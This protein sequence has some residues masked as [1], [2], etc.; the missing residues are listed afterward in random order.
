MPTLEPLGCQTCLATI[1]FILDSKLALSKF[2]QPNYALMM[3]KLAPHC[4]N[5]MNL[6]AH[7]L[8]CN[9]QQTPIYTIGTSI[10]QQISVCIRYRLAI[11]IRAKYRLAH[12]PLMCGALLLDDIECSTS[13]T[14]P[15]AY[16]ISDVNLR[17]QDSNFQ[18]KFQY[19]NHLVCHAWTTTDSC[20]Q[21]RINIWIGNIIKLRRWGQP[22]IGHQSVATYNTGT[23]A[24]FAAR[25][26]SASNVNEWSKNHQT[27]AVIKA[28]NTWSP[29]DVN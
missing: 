27:S 4:W 12:P 26:T 1:K 15:E 11:T 20:R 6:L 22:Q 13:R 3:D 2:N 14:H 16:R 17:F 21:D 18:C 10:W 25:G 24:I 19:C 7:H 23:S 28:Q 29:T 8:H 9:E 5:L